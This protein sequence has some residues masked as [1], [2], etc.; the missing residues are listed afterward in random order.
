MSTML[1]LPSL[2]E[3]EIG[4]GYS[5]VQTCSHLVVPAPPCQVNAL[6]ALTSQGMDR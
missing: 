1:L 4:Q 3:W 5:T 2:A 6:I